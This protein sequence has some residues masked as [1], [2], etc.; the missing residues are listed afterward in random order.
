MTHAVACKI[1]TLFR[2]GASRRGVARTLR[3]SRET[4]RRVLDQSEPARRENAEPRRAQPEIRRPSKLHGF[5]TAIT[6]LLA[7][8]PTITI[9]RLHEELQRS[10]YTGGYTILRHR[11]RALRPRPEEE[12][13]Q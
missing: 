13:R 12:N 1:V 2:G 10:G 3:I 6:E 11:V 4:V 7:R 9:Q 5:E 8:Y